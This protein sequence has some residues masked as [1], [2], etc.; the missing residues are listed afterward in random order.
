MQKKIVEFT[1]LLRKA[2]VRVSV[3]E[4]LDAFVALDE[5]SLED[6]ELF[7]D[8]LR[9]T[10]VK[11]GEDIAD[12]RPPLRPVL[13]GLPRRAAA[14]ARSRRS[15]A[16]PRAS[17]SSSCMEQLRGML[18]N[19]DIDLSDL[20]KALLSMDAERARAAD[21]AGGRGGRGRRIENM[22]Q[23]GFFTRRM[24]EQM[25]M[26]GAAGELRD[27]MERLRE[28]GMSTSSARRAGRAPEGDPGGLRRAS[29]SSPSASSRSRTTTTS[30]GS[31]ARA[32]S[33]RAS[34]T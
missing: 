22:L 30:S 16:C 5:M 19:M 25:D 32:C 23:V 3:A 9:T 27:L 33:R 8:A 29:G 1:N 18:E 17:T 13:V 24:M 12:L 10:M 34:T 2:G 20:A 31:G 4:T 21:P 6:R 15:A 26:E 14:G 28:E 7:K 11:R